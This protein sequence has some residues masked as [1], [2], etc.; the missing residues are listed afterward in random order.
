M[1]HHKDL[2][3]YKRPKGAHKVFGLDLEILCKAERRHCPKLII[4][5]IDYLEQKC[6]DEERLLA[7]PG[8]VAQLKDA[9]AKINYGNRIKFDD[10]GAYTTGDLLKRFLSELPVPLIPKETF[11]RLSEIKADNPKR[12]EDTIAVLQTLARSQ[13][14]TL[15]IILQLCKRV[16]MRSS[17]NKMDCNKLGLV[18]VPALMPYVTDVEAQSLTQSRDAVLKGNEL[19]EYLVPEVE[20]LFKW[21]KHH[22]KRLS[23]KINKLKHYN[24]LA[25]APNTPKRGVRILALD[26]GG[27]R[28]LSE[29]TILSHIAR[30]LYG[31]NGPESTKKLVSSF[32]LICGTSTGSI[33]AMSLLKNSLKDCEDLYYNLGSAIFY[34]SYLYT[35]GRWWRYYRSGDY[36]DGE[37]L[38]KLFA[39]NFGADMMGEMFTAEFPQK[40]FVTA[41]DATSDVF[42]PVLFRSYENKNSHVTGHSKISAPQALRASCAAPTYFSPLVLEEHNYMD[43]G[44]IYNN[45]TELA[46]FEAHALWPDRPIECI[47]SIGTGLPKPN[48]GSENVLSLLGEIIDICTNSDA[49]H[50]RVLSWLDF[51]QI[52]PSYFRFDAN[53]PIGSIR[54]D[55]GDKP[56]L[57]QMCAQTEAYMN[58]GKQTSEVERLMQ[59]LEGQRSG[60]LTENTVNTNNTNVNNK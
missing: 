14:A 24:R 1:L 26:G 19:F 3:A 12:E 29:L 20:N 45:P 22:A 4:C 30:K 39:D 17:T 32:D 35:T 21:N 7:Q 50:K 41:T 18:M 10:L 43:G 6:L 25:A 13:T 58:E 38:Y 53:P 36:Y 34:N 49:I 31:D 37:S 52:K 23:T 9:V 2:Y 54:L 46:I 28:G 59:I 55:T 8:N 56:T 11:T 33:V 57:E 5:I 60:F 42:D 48:P 40:L 16:T 15:E 51:L 27:M 44:F 47:V